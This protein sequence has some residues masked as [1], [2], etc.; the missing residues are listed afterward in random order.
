MYFPNKGYKP[1]A[2]QQKEARLRTLLEQGRARHQAD[3]F[4]AACRIYQSV[5]ADDPAN[6]DATHLLGVAHSQLGDHSTAH[7]FLQRATALNSRNPLAHNNLGNTQSA[8]NDWVNAVQSY[9]R[10]IRIDGKYALAY[11][12]RGL[13]MEELQQFDDALQSY[14][15]AIALEPTYVKAF[16][17]AGLLLQKLG[18]AQEALDHYAAAIG[19]DPQCEEAYLNRGTHFMELQRLNEAILDFDQALAIRPGFSDAYWNKS[20]ALLCM[21]EWAAAWDI[22]GW[23]WQRSDFEVGAYRP[24]LEPV[25]F[26]QAS[27]VAPT[28][29]VFLWAEQGVGDEIFYAS[30]FMD[31]RA[32]FGSVAIQVDARLMSLL[33]R[34][35]PG[36]QFVSKAAPVE[37]RSFD[38]HLSHGDLGYFLRRDTTDFHRIPQSYLKADISRASEIKAH[39]QAGSRPLIGISWRS[40]NRRLG[41]SKSIRLIDLL[42]VLKNSQLRFVDLQYGDT[43]EELQSLQQDHGVEIARCPSVDNF[44]DLDGHAALIHACD[45]VLT[46][47]NTTAH[48]AGALGKTTMLMLSKGESRLWYW[49]NR[50]VDHSVW[51]PA[52]EIFEQARRGEWG[53]VVSDIGT[54]ILEKYRVQ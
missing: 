27:N 36:L 41:D 24:P 10:A 32:R 30:M 28:Q 39:L 33:Q 49:A 44:S 37:A 23:R 13:A 5:L 18:R 26:H 16:I 34:S 21:G 8:L 50:R 52:I 11:Y 17:N 12:N 1:I 42:P 38:V 45:M 40:K 29:K 15:R 43:T 4:E 22:Y 48:I 25:R 14:R 7:D 20:L 47:S 54:S 46:V 3:D 2:L 53:D 9:E 35:M 19:L 6:F 31:A 51:Y